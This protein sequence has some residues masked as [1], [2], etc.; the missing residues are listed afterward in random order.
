MKNIYRAVVVY[1]IGM[2]MLFAGCAFVEMSGTMTRKT[3]EVMTEY[4]KQNDGFLG[5]LAG[6]G[7]RINTAVGSAVENIAKKGK[8]DEP[9]G[10]KPEQ[11]VSANKQ[12]TSA[13]YDAA[14]NQT[15]SERKMVIKAQKRLKE[16]G[17]YLGS[18]DGVI[19]KRTIEAIE[20]YQLDNKLSVTKTL[21][22][23]TLVSLGVT[24]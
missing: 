7:G 19:G 9:G 20:K 13:A 11:F 3:G 12:V 1:G 14:T 22:A 5:T 4:S 16:L 2:S 24:K 10:T 15:I 17:Y 6:V 18:A 21:D 8:T 23:A